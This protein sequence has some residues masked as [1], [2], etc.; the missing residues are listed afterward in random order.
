MTP[1]DKDWI[2]DTGIVLGLIFIL[3]GVKGG[4]R[5]LAVALIFLFISLLFPK[6]LYPA[7]FVWKKITVLLNAVLPKVFFS[8]VFFLVVYPVGLLRR[9]ITG[10]QLTIV[11]WKKVKTV[12]QERNHRYEKNDLQTFY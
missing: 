12:F 6:L 11:E 7:A 5:Y 8:L 4:P 9:I 2:K 3:L 1:I 10:D